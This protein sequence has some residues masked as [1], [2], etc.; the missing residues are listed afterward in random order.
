[1]KHK[2]AE[3]EGVLLDAAVAT[4]EG[5]VYRMGPWDTDRSKTACYVDGFQ[6]MGSCTYDP[7]YTWGIGGPII[8]REQVATACVGLPPLHWMAVVRGSER[9]FYGDSPLVAA[10]R[11]YVATKFGEE[12]E[13]Q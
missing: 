4:A 3:L 8:E 6:Y 13:L 1:M 7:S 10:M 11:A 5:L 9:R 12:V 2:T